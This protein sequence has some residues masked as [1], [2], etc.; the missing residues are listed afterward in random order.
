MSKLIV[1]ESA[2]KAKTIKEYLGKDYEV[3]ASVGHLRD[4]PVTRMGIDVDNDFEPKYVIIKNKKEIVKKLKEKFSKCK[5]IFL[6]TDPD[7]EGEAISWHL[8][9]ILKL[10]LLDKNRV[11]FNEITKHGIEFGMKN[12]RKIDICLVE[13][14]QTRRILDRLVG[15]KLSPFLCQKIQK[16][17]SAGRVQSVA[18]KVI[19]E[20]EK[21]ISLF[22]Q[23]E[24]WII[25]AKFSPEEKSKSFFEARLHKIKDKLVE[26]KNEDEVNK[27]LDNL[28]NK[29]YLVSKIK[30]R[31]KK[32][33]P[34]PPFITSK[35][36]QDAAR[37][38]NF[39]SKRTMKI[40]QELYEGVKIDG[41]T[42]GLV[43]YIR[44]DSLRVSEQAIDE[45][46]D[47]IL[48]E[49]GK[50][51]LFEKRR[52]FKVKKSS[53][54][55]H[56]A[57]RP[58]S[59]VLSPNRI[60]DNLTSD[61]YKLY[62]LI[63]KRFI[64]SQMSDCIHDIT[65]VEIKADDYIFKASGSKIKFDGFSILYFESKD[66]DENNEE[67]IN[68]IPKLEEGNECFLKSFSPKQCFTSPP[69][70]FTEA[71]L[72]KFL[73]END[74]GR[75]S[76]YSSIVSTLIFREYVIKEAK[77]FKPT[78]LGYSVNGLLEKYF[79][80]ILDIKFTAKMEEKLDLIEFGKQQR[81]NVLSGF[82]GD[83]SKKIDEIKEQTKDLKIQLKENETD[84][85]CEKCGKKLVI[86]KGRYGKFMACSNYP[87]C[88]NVKKILK[89]IGVKCPECGND[90]I[91]K[92]SLK[93]RIFYGCSSYPN[94]K[95]V[96]WLL[97]VDRRCPKCDNILFNSYKNIVCKNPDCDFQ[98]KI[99]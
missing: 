98:E 37:K 40:A 90:I 70:R 79:S 83:F 84:E 73:E 16:G 64:A 88:K 81:I 1:V 3:F 4:L 10:N 29:K 53:Q 93:K 55:A 78:E 19:V 92:K 44:T 57:I 66:D 35:L 12:A 27:I 52:V 5:E 23:E 68:K 77:S 74:I 60:K 43:T 72:I 69:P 46:R 63:W 86:K 58:T 34:T 75:P 9:C 62:S 14:Q 71:S 24:Y 36:Q 54:D 38:L 26:L 13:S 82:Y 42:T 7:R 65:T 76:T 48:K 41:K 61:Q 31:Q 30:R 56:E 20:R 6:A 85:I 89:K 50:N 49:W 95:F 11:T 47:F 91:E 15:Y 80:E 2:A 45:C 33:S 97:P 99:N 87:D 21:E 59:C 67:E 8:S 22:E 25:N 39:S 18:L 28:K 32:Q 17:L 96:S 51:Y 94:C